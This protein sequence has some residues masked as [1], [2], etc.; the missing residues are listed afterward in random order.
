MRTL[1]SWGM[2][3]TLGTILA[4]AS[5]Q[6]GDDKDEKPVKRRATTQWKR[7]T[8]WQAMG[9]ATGL[10]SPPEA[11]KPADKKTAEKK[12][13]PKK[14]ETATVAAK[15][16]LVIDDEGDT[17]SR[18]EAAYLRRSAAA[19]KLQEIAVHTDDP[20]LMKRAEQLNEQAWAAYSQRS[21][22]RGA[23]PAADELRSSGKSSKT[24]TVTGKDGGSPV[25]EDKR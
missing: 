4:A 24:Y 1:G 6:A 21:M 15:K 3:V 12:P 9:R 25:K 23:V 2:L 19:L 11:K 22:E 10:E 13:D 5:V 14:K 8:V 7:T 17:Q 20:E 18:E 16:D